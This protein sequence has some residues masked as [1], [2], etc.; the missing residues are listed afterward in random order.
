MLLVHRSRRAAKAVRTVSPVGELFVASVA[1]AM[2]P[3]AFG[4]AVDPAWL[5]EPAPEFQLLDLGGACSL[6]R[7]RTQ[8]LPPRPLARAPQQPRLCRIASCRG[9]PRNPR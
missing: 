5:R 8:L 4:D 3:A 1:F 9:Q 6:P 7:L 2:L